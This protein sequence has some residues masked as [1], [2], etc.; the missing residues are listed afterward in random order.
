MPDRR[1][2]RGKRDLALLQLLG[3]AGSAPR[4]GR[5]PAD[6][7]RRRTPTVEH[8]RLRAAIGHS[9]SWWVTVRYG[10]RGRTRVIPLDQDALSAITARVKVR[11][12][13]AT[14][15]LL[16]SLPRT[17]QP[18]RA[19]STRDIA[20]I[21][22]RHAANAGLPGD[23]RSP[24]VYADLWVMPTRRGDFYRALALLPMSSISRVALRTA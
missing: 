24:H 21:V 19:L 11:P 23:R 3:S 1:T 22:A 12:V 9:T 14:E 13:A 15:Q 4:R 17:G 10:K 5:R 2:R 7:R 8:P 16:L 18:P 6:Q 20:R